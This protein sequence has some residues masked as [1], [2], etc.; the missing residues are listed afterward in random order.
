MALYGAMG[1]DQRCRQGKQVPKIRPISDV[2]G[3]ELPKPLLWKLKIP[4][5]VQLVGWPT[6]WVTLFYAFCNNTFLVS[7]FP[8]Y[9]E[10]PRRNFGPR[11]FCV[12]LPV[13]KPLDRNTPNVH[14]WPIRKVNS[15]KNSICRIKIPAND[16][17]IIFTTP[18][19]N[20]KLNRRTQSLT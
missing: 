2:V 18:N 9:P 16:Q 10:N 3:L 13:T 4:E 1:D 20:Q 12:S 14:S 17:T 8:V 7:L 19:P 15:I 11:F 6:E 5:P